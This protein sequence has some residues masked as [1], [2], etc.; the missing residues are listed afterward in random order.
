M[1]E[2][3]E[4]PNGSKIVESQEL[5]DIIH[6][7]FSE[8]VDGNLAW[9]EALLSTDPNFLM[10]GT[11]PGEWLSG[12]D[13]RDFLTEAGKVVVGKFDF[14]VEKL[15]AFTVQNTFGWGRAQ[16]KL[17][18]RE[19]KREIKPRWTGVFLRDNEQEPWKLIFLHTSIGVPNDAVFEN[20]FDFFKTWTSRA[21]T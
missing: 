10:V 18:F 15:E 3:S 12:Q 9:R 21:K 17:Q 7:W 5:K 2:Q 13:G 11:D 1:P 8:A 14:T 20:L 4:F 19:S 16:A 6:H